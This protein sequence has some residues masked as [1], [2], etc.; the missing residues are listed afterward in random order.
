MANEKICTEMKLVGVLLQD[1]IN[2]DLDLGSFTV[3]KISELQEILLHCPSSD[4]VTWCHRYTE[5][6]GENRHFPCSLFALA[7][8]KEVLPFL[9]SVF[10]QW[11]FFFFCEGQIR[12]LSMY[13]VIR[14]CIRD[15]MT[16]FFDIIKGLRQWC[17]QV[18]VLLL[19][20]YVCT[21]SSAL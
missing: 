18:E 8:V 14:K 12:Y 3:Y 9:P 7:V 13:E 4:Y 1:L 6:S 16:G 15:D 2:S 20:R 21:N 5:L 17:W 11:F 19:A 10:L